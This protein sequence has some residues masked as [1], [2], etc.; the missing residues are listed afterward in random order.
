MRAS[1]FAS[2]ALCLAATA[3]VAQTPIA[4][5]PVEGAKVSGALEVANGKAAIGSSGT[6]TAGDKAVHVT[7]PDRGEIQ[8]C[9]TTTIHLATDRSVTTSQGGLLM[10][11]DR[12]ALEARLGT[13]KFSDVLMTPDFRILVSGP[14]SADLRVRVNAKGDTCVENHGDNAPYVTVSSLFDGGAYRVQSNQR[15]LFEHGSLHDV[16]DHER[17]ACGCPAAS[18]AGENSFPVAVSAGL[19]PPPA[20]AAPTPAPGEVQTK[21]TAKLAYDGQTGKTSSVEAPEPAQVA[22]VQPPPPPPPAP[23]KKENTGGGNIFKK[24]GHFFGHIFGRS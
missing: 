20:T 16:V 8:L 4:Y 10:A 12:G 18:P 6:I 21:V 7:L 3:G 14:G 22:V 2:L 17:E 19:A 9:S 5:V 13:G 23:A 11:L 15:V 1:H 24:I